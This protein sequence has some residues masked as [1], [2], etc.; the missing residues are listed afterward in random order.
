MAYSL[1]RPRVDLSI[2]EV[3][4]GVSGVAGCVLW[5]R[6]GVMVDIEEGEVLRSGAGEV[7]GRRI[8]E[9]L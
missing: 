9:E 4:V 7:G 5:Y 3:G 2:R 8:G 6:F 1:W